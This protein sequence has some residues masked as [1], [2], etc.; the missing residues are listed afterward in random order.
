MSE[1]RM[2]AKNPGWKGGQTKEQ[3]AEYLREWRR[4]NEAYVRDREYKKR[5]GITIE[6]YEALLERQDG[7]CAICRQPCRRGRLA[8][9]HCHA[10]GR[11]RGLLC[12]SCNIIL[13]LADDSP[14]W[15]ERAMKYLAAQDEGKE[16]SHASA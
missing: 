11:V 13:G 12:R 10:T 8:V 1:S 16:V 14:A 5:F 15:M 4:K 2:G 3:K 6:E 7:R 9:D